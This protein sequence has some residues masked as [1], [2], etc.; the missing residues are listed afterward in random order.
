MADKDYISKKDLEFLV[1]HLRR[2]IK[3]KGAVLEECFRSDEREQ[4]DRFFCVT[5][6]KE[7]LEKIEEAY[8]NA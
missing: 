2:Y 8:K 3:D 1:Y 5:E 7:V 4:W 6:A